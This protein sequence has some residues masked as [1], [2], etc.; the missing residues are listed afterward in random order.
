M[1]LLTVTLSHQLD[2]HQKCHIVVKRLSNFPVRMNVK[3]WKLYLEQKVRKFHILCQ[4]KDLFSDELDI[5]EP[6]I[7]PKPLEKLPPMKLI[8][9]DLGTWQK[10]PTTEPPEPVKE[11]KRLNPDLTPEMAAKL[12]PVQLSVGIYSGLKR[13]GLVRWSFQ[14]GTVVDMLNGKLHSIVEW[15]KSNPN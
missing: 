8:R 3:Y 6:L 15:K 14:D 11:R 12:I 2:C 4:I 10:L 7:E 13:D 5:S 9:K 1:S